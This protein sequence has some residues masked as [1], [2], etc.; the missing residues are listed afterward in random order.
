MSFKR[1]YRTERN[2][3]TKSRPAGICAKSIRIAGREKDISGWR[4]QTSSKNIKGGTLFKIKVY[5]GRIN[6]NRPPRKD[7]ANFRNDPRPSRICQTYST[8]HIKTL[9]TICKPKVSGKIKKDMV[10]ISPA[11]KRL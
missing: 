6:V 2:L 10:D 5:I 7:E 4:S 3:F 1:I 9:M 11:K 8:S